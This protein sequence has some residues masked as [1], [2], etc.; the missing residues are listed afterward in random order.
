MKGLEEQLNKMLGDYST[1]NESNN[2]LF[3]KTMKDIDKIKDEDQAAFLKQ[4]LS[5][6]KSGKLDINSFLNNLN[7]LKNA[8]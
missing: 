7:N 2:A 3:D 8:S 5:D 6:A 4:S 1:L